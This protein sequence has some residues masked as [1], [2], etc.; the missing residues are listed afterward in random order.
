MTGVDASGNGGMTLST[1]NLGRGYYRTLNESRNILKC[2][3][4][5]ACIGGV[6]ASDYCER[7]TKEYVRRSVKAPR[8]FSIQFPTMKCDSPKCQVQ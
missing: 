5:K 4:Q 1:L 2:H 3:Q 7:A 8:A 6:E